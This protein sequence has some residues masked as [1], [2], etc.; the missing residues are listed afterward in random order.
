MFNLQVDERSLASMRAMPGVWAAYAR[1]GDLGLVYERFWP[2]RGEGT[3][4]PTLTTRVRDGG[5]TFLQQ[6]KFFLGLVNFSTGRVDLIYW[7]Q[8][9]RV[10]GPPWLAHGF[11]ATAPELPGSPCAVS[12]SPQPRVP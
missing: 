3:R 4:K 8:L 6:T 12:W 11:G 9:P 2:G 10:I 7:S 5:A 1:P